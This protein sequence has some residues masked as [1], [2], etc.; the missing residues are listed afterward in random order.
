MPA[1]VVRATHT[2][3]ERHHPPLRPTLV[4]V[5]AAWILAWG[6]QGWHPAIA[7]AVAPSP[8]LNVNEQRILMP[9]VSARS[10]AG[11]AGPQVDSVLVDLARARSADMATRSY[12]SH[13]TPEGG[14]FFDLLGRYQVPYLYA[15]ETIARNNYADD[16]APSVAAE[17]FLDSP[18]HRAV[19]LDPQYNSVGVGQAIGTDRMHY[20]TVI[21]VRR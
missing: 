10:A 13:Y 4:T 5:L 9:L 3:P 16:Q 18:P 15:G 7:A 14:T 12:F 11:A 19:I 1:N 21:L 20:Y 2:A 17:A 8:L 6:V